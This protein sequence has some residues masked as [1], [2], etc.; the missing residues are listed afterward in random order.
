MIKTLLLL[1]LPASGKSEIRRYLESMTDEAR[2]SAFGL[3]PLQQVDDFPYVH[4]MRRISEEAI[5][6]GIDPP[7]F[8]DDG[9]FLD[10]RDWGTLTQLINDD[11]RSLL[12]GAGDVPHPGEWVVNRMAEARR[13]VGADPALSRLDDRTRRRLGEAILEEARAVQAEVDGPSAGPEGT[14]LIEFARGMPAAAACPPLPPYGYRY[15]LSLLSPEILEDAR[16]LYVF[17]TPEASRQKNRERTVVGEEGSTLHHGVPEQ[18]MLEDYGSDD[19]MWMMSQARV[20]G[21][22]EVSAGNKHYRVPAAVFDNRGDH[23]SFLRESPSSWDAG[24]LAELENRLS[25]AFAE[26]RK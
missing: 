20:P 11:Y 3:G 10:R 2:E 22:V 14:V 1:A 17:V 4:L 23:T 7:F 15:S 21:T 13:L 6:V 25:R 24:A 9:P 16:I 5:A 8:A 19:F 12:V 18:V 26:L